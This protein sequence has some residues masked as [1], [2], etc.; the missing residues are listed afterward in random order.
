MYIQ[1]IT[2][3][4][5]S[6]RKSLLQTLVEVLITSLSITDE[7]VMTCTLSAIR[8]ICENSTKT[9]ELAQLL[10]EG[11]VVLQILLKEPNCYTPLISLLRNETLGK[12]R[13]GDIFYIINCCINGFRLWD[14]RANHRKGF[15]SA[16]L[17]EAIEVR[18]PPP[19]RI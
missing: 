11:L 3:L 6:T 9:G 19:P 1:A 17:L 16:G 13:R 5:L 18:P 2:E 12:Q 7:R 15:V 14:L 8:K 10:W 4:L